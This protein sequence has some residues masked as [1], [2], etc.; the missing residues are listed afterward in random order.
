MQKFPAGLLIF[1]LLAT[2]ALRQGEGPAFAVA[3][4]ESIVYRDT[5]DLPPVVFSHEE[6]KQA[7]VDCRAC[8]PRIFKIGRGV[9]DRGNA[10]TMLS[11]L[12][13]KFCG[14]C[15]NGKKAFRAGDKGTCDKC[16]V[17]GR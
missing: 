9:A 3:N 17:R 4:D 14:A 15:H 7:G 11:L 8:H 2:G 1:F 13:G 6:H 5:E 10:M 16:H 12:Q